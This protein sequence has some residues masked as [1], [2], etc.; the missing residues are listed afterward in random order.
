MRKVKKKLPD[1]YNILKRDSKRTGFV[2]CGVCPG[3]SELW[4]AYNEL[5]QED[6]GLVRDIVGETV[7]DPCDDSRW[8]SR[9]G[10]WY[11]VVYTDGSAHGPEHKLTARAGWVVWYSP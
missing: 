4:Q 1:V 5:D 11:L 8:E 10:K 7:T 9:D 6:P 2:N 3:D